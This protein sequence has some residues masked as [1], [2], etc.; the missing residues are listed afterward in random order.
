QLH[1]ELIAG[2]DL[3]PEL[4]VLDRDEKHQLA[5]AI[6]YAFQHQHAGG[7]RHGLNDEHA[8]HDRKIG[9]VPV[10]EGLVGGNV[11]DADDALR[12]ELDDAV[13]QEHGIAMRQY[14]PDFIH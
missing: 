13:D 7:L 14:P 2:H 11:L 12:L 1:A 3:P 9:K 5:V 6:L 8:G 10:E 4:G